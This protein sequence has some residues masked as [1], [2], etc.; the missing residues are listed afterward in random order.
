[1]ENAPVSNISPALRDALGSFDPRYPTDAAVLRAIRSQIGDELANR[2]FRTL[3]EDLLAGRRPPTP[4]QAPPPAPAAPRRLEEPP[5][6]G[7]EAARERARRY[8]AGDRWPSGI[9]RL[10]S[11]SGRRSDL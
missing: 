2:P 3:V 6:T 10:P 9:A 11:G 8:A 7:L 4:P 5:P 1:M